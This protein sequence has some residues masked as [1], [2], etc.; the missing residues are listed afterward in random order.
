MT[1]I[2]LLSDGTTFRFKDCKAADYSAGILKRDGAH[3]ASFRQDSVLAIVEE[4]SLAEK[5]KRPAP[6]DR[7]SAEELKSSSS[8]GRPSG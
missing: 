7:P 6:G 5:P 1:L 2:I 4:E 8:K 3:V